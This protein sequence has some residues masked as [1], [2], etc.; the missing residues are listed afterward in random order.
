MK[1]PDNKILFLIVT[2]VLI[3]TSVISYT[4]YRDKAPIVDTAVL[5][6]NNDPYLIAVENKYQETDADADGLMDWEETLWGTDPKNP[7]TD[8]D[9]TKDGEEV[10]I[11]RNPLKKG[12]TDKMPSGSGVKST[13]TL[14]TPIN[15]DILN[16]VTGQI[17]QKIL[18]KAG[19]AGGEEAGI[20]LAN[21]LKD[22]LAIE[23]IYLQNNLI[24]FDPKDT[25]K[26]EKYANLLINTVVEEY[27]A[28]NINA[29]NIYAY[30]EAY[31]NIGFRLSAINVPSNLAG[32]HTD[33]IN[34]FHILSVLARRVAE[35]EQKPNNDPIIML[36]TYPDY[37]KISEAQNLIFEQIKLYYKNN[38]IIFSNTK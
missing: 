33:Y 27:N 26:M 25:G 17:S 35:A 1:I 29:T 37:I 24:T 23:K 22:K 4:E 19:E 13:N 14:D 30:S 2:I 21:Q 32:I 11:G 12:P 7:D 31:K 10:A 20:E 38:G 8:G 34:N 36:A 16:T 3:I 9:K 18:I 15:K 5:P 28:A 6:V